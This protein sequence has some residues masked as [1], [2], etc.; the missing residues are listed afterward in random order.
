VGFGSWRF[1][2]S[3]PH[4]QIRPI[5][6]PIRA[7]TQMTTYE[8]T[9]GIISG[10]AASP[11][12]PIAYLDTN[13]V[14]ALAQQDIDQ[15]DVHALFQLVDLMHAGRVALVTSTVAKEEIERV[16]A[17]HR[18]PHQGTYALL[19]KIPVVD[20]QRLFPRRVQ[21]FRPG[22]SQI[23]GPSVIEDEDL[24][25]LRAILPDE[26]DARHLFQ[27]SKNGASYFV[28]ADRR[29]I[30]SRA[31]EIESAFPIRVMTPTQLVAELAAEDAS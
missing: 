31:R 17:E 1:K 4:S 27:A 26:N 6:C 14:S 19:K 23:I 25:R 9:G 3:H 18:A 28:T 21:A 5:E 22:R 7:Q 10:T 2:S 8:K 13:L 16:P 15:A 30:L 29:T 20:E 24:G 12:P 11:P